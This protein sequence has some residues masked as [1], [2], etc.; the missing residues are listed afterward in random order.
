MT[1]YHPLALR[2]KVAISEIAEVVQRGRN[3][4]GHPVPIQELITGT[5][6]RHKVDQIVHPLTRIRHL[7][8]GASWNNVIDREAEPR[9]VRPTQVDPAVDATRSALSKHRNSVSMPT[10]AVTPWRSAEELPTT[11]PVVIEGKRGG[12]SLISGV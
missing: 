10:R 8:D 11:A 9:F 6:C 7:G 2:K 4:V 5:A 12:A 3:R 1:R